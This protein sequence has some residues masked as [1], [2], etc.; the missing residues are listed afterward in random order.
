[1]NF[2]NCPAALYTQ[3]GRNIGNDRESNRNSF[4]S[5]RSTGEL[6]LISFGPM[7][8]PS[9]ATSSRSTR[10]KPG[11]NIRDRIFC[12]I[13]MSATSSLEAISVSF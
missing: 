1:M 12:I 7:H 9:F 10:L 4:M 8:E 11:Q 5:G 6:A 2:S 3:R 13:G